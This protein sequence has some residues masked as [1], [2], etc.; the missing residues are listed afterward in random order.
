MPDKEPIKQET[1]TEQ[2]PAEPPDKAVIA[3]DEVQRFARQPKTLKEIVNGEEFKKALAAVLSPKAMRRFLRQLLTAMLRNPEL[4]DCTKESY[5]RCAFDL[6]LLGL[7]PDGRRAHL[8]PFRN[9]KVCQCGHDMDAH[10]GQDCTKCGC[11]QRRSATECTLIVDY[12]GY[13][14]LVRRSGDVSYIHADVVYDRDE[15]S[16]AF[17]TEAHLKHKPSLENRGT[18]RIAFYSYARLKDGTEDFVVLSPEEVEK[19]RKRSKA[20]NNGPW[21]TDYDEM[22]K[23]T[24]FRRHSKWLPLSVEARDAIEK[25]DEAIDVSGWEEMIEAAKP[26]EAPEGKRPKLFDRLKAAQEIEAAEQ[27]P[28]ALEGKES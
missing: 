13:V 11:R 1:N 7:E 23:K 22:G 20:A 21:V 6:A 18:R 9:N 26:T 16:Y 3:D 8:I 12:K 19:V 17:G 2:L 4:G 15:W 5:F 27:Q 24:A 14:E 10:R 25:D 28:E